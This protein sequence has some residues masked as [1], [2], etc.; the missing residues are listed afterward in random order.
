MAFGRSWPR[1]WIWSPL[2]AVLL[3]MTSAGASGPG[4]EPRGQSEP[5]LRRPVALAVTRDGKALFAANERSGSLSVIDPPGGRLVDEFDVGRSLAD[6]ATLAG[7]RH[8]LAVD[9]GAGALILLA[10]REGAVEV[11]SRLDVGPD[12]VS[13]LASAD[14][15]SCVVASLWSRRLTL[16]ELSGEAGREHPTPKVAWTLDLPFSPRCLLR[17]PG[18]PKL[19]VADAFGGKLAV[20]DLDRRALESVRTLPAHNIRGLATTADGRKLVVAHQVL[21]RLART[22]FEDVHWGSMI[23][24]HLR[25]LSLDDVLA[26]GSD[27]DLLRGG[28]LMSLGE[29]GDA[30]GDPAA[31]AA[32]GGN[33][34]VALAGVGEVAVVRGPGEP[35]WRVSVGRRPSAVVLSPDGAT[36]YV[37]DTSDDT[38][39]VVDLGT[40]ARRATI[41][42]GPRPELGPVDRG[43]QLFHDAKLSHDGWMS[44]QSCHTDGHS[45]GLVNDTLG[46][47]TFGAP[48]RVP[49]LLGAGKTGPWTWIGTVDRLE[50]QVR[51]SI[52]TTMQGKSPT[53][54]QVGDL[55]AYLRSLAPPTPAQTAAGREDDPASSRG[56]DVFRARDCANCHAPPAYTTPGRFDVGLVDEVGNRKFNPPSLLGVS[57]RQPLLHDGRAATLEDVFRTH[58]HPGG[59]E[60]SPGEIADLAAFLR[61]L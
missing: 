60:L 50:D 40:S 45:N 57:R 5:R 58:R 1:R 24:N 13:V 39:S 37:A 53:D 54:E 9:R 8:L 21:R 32:D 51:K 48:K 3:L 56:R 31:L 16:V 36:A 27:A 28:R 41:S 14:G 30:A 19:V 4:P 35:Q 26:P 44:C 15:S 2:P 6:V 23:G 38:V 43:E 49:S 33:L 22:S 47:G 18:R 17:V 10:R 55:A 42:L 29:V 61:G 25:F 52:E 12:P 34:V 11:V 59:L 46:D 20:A 7:D